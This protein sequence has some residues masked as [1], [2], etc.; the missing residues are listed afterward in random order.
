[1]KW[2][3]VLELAETHLDHYIEVPRVT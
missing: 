2:V 3:S 1:M